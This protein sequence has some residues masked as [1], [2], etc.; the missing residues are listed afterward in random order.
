MEV[1]D[2]RSLWLL[3]LALVLAVTQNYNQEWP[4]FEEKPMSKEN[5]NSTLDFFIQSFNNASNDTFLFQVQKLIRTRVQLTTGVEYLVTVRIGR[6]TCKRTIPAPSSASCPLQGKK[7]RKSLV[8][9]SLIYTVPWINYFQL[10][11]NSCLEG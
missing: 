7:L 10:W 6:T 3:L 11:N 2:G 9:E 8:C 1:R 5:M 4:G